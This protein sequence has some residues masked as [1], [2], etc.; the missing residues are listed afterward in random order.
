M[1]G[2]QLWYNNHAKRDYEGV[3][4]TGPKARPVFGKAKAKNV[5]AGSKI[6]VYNVHAWREPAII[7]GDDGALFTGQTA[8]G[9]ITAATERGK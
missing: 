9:S 8:R 6:M 1:G 2:L 5:P 4:L 3:S 7:F